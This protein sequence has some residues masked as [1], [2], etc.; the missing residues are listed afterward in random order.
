MDAELDS[1]A[2]LLEVDIVSGCWLWTGPRN[3][4]YAAVVVGGREWLGHRLM[5]VWF[6]GGHAPG[7]EL[8]HICSTTLCIRPNHLQPVTHR[9]NSARR[10][11]RAKSPDTPF[12]TD[13]Y[14]CETTI[15]LL[16]WAGNY[17]LPAAPSHWGSPARSN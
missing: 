15:S 4:E 6:V 12:W 17:G 8:D 11:R 5:Y 14:L 1:I 7:R 2:K 10:G 16:M 9:V 13:D 3:G